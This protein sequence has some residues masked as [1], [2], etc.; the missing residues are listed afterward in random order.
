MRVLYSWNALHR[1]TS[2]LNSGENNGEVGVIN[3]SEAAK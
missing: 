1:A 2:D 3:I